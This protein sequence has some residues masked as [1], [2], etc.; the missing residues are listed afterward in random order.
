VLAW[1]VA[2]LV[3]RLRKQPAN[4]PRLARMARWLAV[5]AAGLNLVFIVAFAAT[6]AQGLSG[7]SPYPPSWF[8][9]LLV[10]PI[11]TSVMSIA[12]LVCT[13]LAWKRRYWSVVGRV[14]YSVVTLAAL[15][16][17]WLADYWNLV[18]FRL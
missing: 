12:L 17:V 2:S 16:F 7:A 4:D 3:R 13:I 10:L 1:P 6:L 5:A 8:V 18:G 15:A 14:H 11:L 9:A